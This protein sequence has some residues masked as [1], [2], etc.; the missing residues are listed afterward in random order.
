MSGDGISESQASSGGLLSKMTSGL[1]VRYVLRNTAL[2]SGGKGVSAVLGL[3]YLAL[4]AHA[5]GAQGLG[6][7][8]IIHSLAVAF[9]GIVG[10][11]SWEIGYRAT[12]NALP[13]PPRPRAPAPPG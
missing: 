7:L 8:L 12:E 13:A 9:T 10:F 6:H 5:L 4:G 3:G 2:L 1:R 11:K